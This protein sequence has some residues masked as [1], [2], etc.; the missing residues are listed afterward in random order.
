[1]DTERDAFHDFTTFHEATLANF[2]LVELPDREPDFISRSRSAYWDLGHGV[3]RCSDHWGEIRR[4][5][6]LFEGCRM[7]DRLVTGYCLYARFLPVRRQEVR[8]GVLRHDDLRR[9]AT[10]FLGE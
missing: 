9:I 10:E 8:E 7:R 3:V 5:Y 6:W 1:M 2:T 4:S